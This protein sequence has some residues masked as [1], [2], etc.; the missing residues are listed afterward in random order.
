RDRRLHPRRRRN[1]C[2]ATRRRTPRSAR[3]REP[4]AASHPSAR[5]AR[6]ERPADGPA[7]LDVRTGP[8][9]CGLD[10]REAGGGV[11]DV[12]VADVADAEDLPL[13]RAL[14]A[15]ERDAEAVAQREHELAR[16]DA[17]GRTDRGHDRR[18]VLVWREE[19]EAHRLHAFAAGTAEPDV[20][21]EDG[22]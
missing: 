10:A 5:F 3:G 20:A 7:A 14:T 1:G 18:P 19:L 13:E 15:R 9:E 11:E 12:G 8:R 22:V 17:V 2:A 16:V 4:A 6:L 21:L